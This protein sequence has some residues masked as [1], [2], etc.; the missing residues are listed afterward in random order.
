MHRSHG[1]LIREG[2]YMIITRK[3]LCSL[4]D[5]DAPTARTRMLCGAAAATLLVTTGVACTRTPE[6]P[7][8]DWTVEEIKQHIQVTD[9]TV[10]LMQSLSRGERSHAE[11][12]A[13]L[14]PVVAA[15]E[16][17][18]AVIE[19]H[20]VRVSIEDSGELDLYGDGLVCLSSPLRS[21]NLLTDEVGRD[22]IYETEITPAE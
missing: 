6:P 4:T 21:I 13:A 10:G 18:G 9:R 19:R 3:L 5:A 16:S 2:P 11:I 22:P 12:R 7:P 14:R 17:A 20:P 1:R 15:L 8:P